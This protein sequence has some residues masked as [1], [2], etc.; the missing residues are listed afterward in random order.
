MAVAP[1]SWSSSRRTDNC[2]AEESKTIL[3]R[4]TS[5]SP[6]WLLTLPDSVFSHSAFDKQSCML[7]Q[8]TKF[9]GEYWHKKG[10]SVACRLAKREPHSPHQRGSDQHRQQ[11]STVF[12]V[13]VRNSLESAKSKTESRTVQLGIWPAEGFLTVE[14]CMYCWARREGKNCF[15]QWE[16]SQMSENIQRWL[17]MYP[18]TYPRKLNNKP[19]KH[20]AQEYSYMWFWFLTSTSQSTR[21]ARMCSVIPA[22]RLI[23]GFTRV[24]SCRAQEH[25]T[26]ENYC[27]S[28]LQW[29]LSGT[30]TAGF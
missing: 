9:P 7:Y 1:T 21:I 6:H 18:L 22:C 12:H 8:M 15:Q 14:N 17:I 25:G 19:S 13:Q 27:K 20:R 10:H 11:S 28:I 16:T 29:N 5:P 24:F 30:T 26:K 3:L 23:Y 4:A 2:K